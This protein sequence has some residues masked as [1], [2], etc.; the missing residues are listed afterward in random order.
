MDH[1]ELVEN[2]GL[3]E[4]PVNLGHLVNP[5]SQ[6]D[7]GNKEKKDQRDLKEGLGNLVALDRLDYPDFQESG[8]CPAFL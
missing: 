1:L 5:V 4:H 2:Q 3:L 7:L 8:V 6:E